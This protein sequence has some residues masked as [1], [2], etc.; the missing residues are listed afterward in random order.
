MRARLIDE[1]KLQYACD[2]AICRT[3]FKKIIDT[4]Q[5]KFKYDTEL[6]HITGSSNAFQ[7]L[8]DLISIFIDGDVLQK[9]IIE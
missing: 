7:Y 2:I 1:K 6:I 3:F 5:E 4:M 8:F 9:I